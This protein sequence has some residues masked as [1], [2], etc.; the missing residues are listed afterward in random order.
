[1][2]LITLVSRVCIYYGRPHVS[3]LIYLLSIVAM[4]LYDEGKIKFSN[5]FL[6]RALHK[7]DSL[8]K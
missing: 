3:L 6:F 5:Y 4:H 7:F 1:M 8:M 2:L